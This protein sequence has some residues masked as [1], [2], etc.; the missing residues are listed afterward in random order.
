MYVIDWELTWVTISSIA[1]VISTVH[2]IVSSRKAKFA[3]KSLNEII[4]IQ[5]N[6]HNIIKTEVSVAVANAVIAQASASAIINDEKAITSIA[7]KVADNLIDAKT[8]KFEYSEGV[9]KIT[10]PANN[11]QNQHSLIFKPK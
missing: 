1:A 6:I 2:A 8:P 4:K 7:T 10:S 9:L 5:N 11:P 3:E